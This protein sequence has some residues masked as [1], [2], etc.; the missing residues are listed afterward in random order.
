MRAFKHALFGTP[1]AREN[2][3]FV[4]QDQRQQQ[5]SPHGQTKNPIP[6]RVQR[7]SSTPEKASGDLFAER[8]P[9]ILITPGTGGNRR[10]TVSF[11]AAAKDCE[12]RGLSAKDTGSDETKAP[13][14]TSAP[15]KGNNQTT[16]LVS[17]QHPRG[18]TEFLLD[19]SSSVVRDAFDEVTTNMSFPRSSSGQ[20]W[21]SEFDS[22][23]TRSELEMKKLVRKEQVA[24]KYGK[25]RDNTASRLDQELR[26]EQQKVGILEKQVEE[27]KTELE[28]CKKLLDQAKMQEDEARS[29]PRL[30]HA[31]GGHRSKSA[32]ASERPTHGEFDIHNQNSNEPLAMSRPSWRDRSV[33]EVQDV[34]DGALVS[35]Q[36]LGPQLGTHQSIDI[37]AEA[38]TKTQSAKKR[39]SLI[40]GGQRA[41]LVPRSL[42]PDN[43]TSGNRIS[44]EDGIKKNPTSELTDE[45][46]QAAR[47][48][49]AEKRSQREQH[50]TMDVQ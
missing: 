38:A 15:L 21:K 30:R 3:A 49:Q 25:H 41:P 6:P 18:S 10:K 47:K 35:G 36:D 9:G 39:E 14:R 17:Q 33:H 32:N 7:A 46:R 12:H 8:K 4:R 16:K 45:R 19:D 28:K 27:Y 11:G 2:D 24:K 22:Y 23:S 40:K 42:N 43:A 13:E 20:Y 44:G 31:P 48:R 37:W 1:Q 50:R 29:V 5:S 34:S 26:R